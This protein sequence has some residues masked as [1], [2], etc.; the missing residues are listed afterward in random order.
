[1]G[2]ITLLRRDAYLD[3]LRPGVKPD[4]WC[5]L[6]NSPLNSLGLFPNDMVHRAGDVIAKAE[7]ELHTTQPGSSHGGYASMKQNHYQPYQGGWNRQQEANG[8]TSTC[9]ES[10]VLAQCSFGMRNHSNRGKGKRT[11]SG[12]RNPKSFK[13]KQNKWQLLCKFCSKPGPF[14]LCSL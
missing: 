2:N 7:T 6:S 14:V 1:M 3:H 9:Q 8:S 12:G 4:T 11:G 5:A 10:D 13:G